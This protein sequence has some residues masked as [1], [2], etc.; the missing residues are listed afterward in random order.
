MPEEFSDVDAFLKHRSGAGGGGGSFMKGW[1]EKGTLAVWLH[2]RGL[3]ISV[4]HVQFP[5]HQIKT[6]A[7]TRVT[8]SKF[9][10]SNWVSWES[11]ATM[12]RMYDRNPDGTME[13]PFRRDPL[14]RMLEEVY[15]AV[16]AGDLSTFDEVFRFMGSSDPKD[17]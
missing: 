11:D 16:R 12:K 17:D 4:W 9:F 6:D 14:C 15:Q 3:P 1:K 2:T 5:R 7:A 13:H 10:M 8:T